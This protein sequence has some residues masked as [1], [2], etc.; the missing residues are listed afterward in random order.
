MSSRLIYNIRQLVNT[1]A[2]NHLLRGAELAGLPCIDNAWI[3]IEDDH[4]AA[5]G[6]MSALPATSGSSAK[7]HRPHR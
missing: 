4:I 1:R 7:Q 5:Y 3:H 2:E 6:P